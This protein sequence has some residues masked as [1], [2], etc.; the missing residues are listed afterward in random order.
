MSLIQRAA[1]ALSSLALVLLT[2]MV[3]SSAEIPRSEPLDVF[4]VYMAPASAGGSDANDGLT[5]ATGVV[6]LARVQEVLRQQAP[7][8]DVEIRIKQGTYVARQF[9]WT[10][11]VPGH[12][13]S[14][15]PIDYVSGGGFPAGGLPIFR[16]AK[17]ANGKYYG[18]FWLR[19]KLP[20]DPA[21]PLRGGGDSNL[22]FTYLQVD[23]YA[24][25]GVSIWGD[26]GT[27]TEDE[28]YNPP[29]R[30]RG[31]SLGL[32][33][34]RFFGMQFRNLGSKWNPTD[35]GY[36]GIV[37]TNSSN[38]QIIN[39]HFVNIENTGSYAGH[40]HG[41]YITHFSSN[42]DIEQNKFSYISGDAVKSRNLSNNNTIY[43]NTFTRAGRTSY[44]RGEFCDRQCAIDNAMAR[45]C[46]SYGDR[47]FDNTVNS[48]YGGAQI[49]NWSLSPAGLTY[50][51]VSPCSIP[52]DQQRIRTGGNTS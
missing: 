16:N 19:P 13:V 11:Y 8:T 15:M 41:V 48:G 5:P 3:A 44:Y 12:S 35:W 39:S 2:P 46:A 23:Y 25:G 49:S 4:T 37:L 32:N 29:L 52:S 27:D 47:F 21:D 18:G 20:S 34:N 17:D 33:N 45:Q 43:Y 31:P 24:S 42:N 14:F 7:A 10:F 38:N 9:D 28:T 36:G 30:V 50:A 51:G 6:T 1:A 40:I 26:S 22:R